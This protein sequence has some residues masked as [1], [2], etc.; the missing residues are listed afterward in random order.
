MRTGLLLIIIL[1]GFG[2]WSFGGVIVITGPGY[3][4][5]CLGYSFQI[6]AG[7]PETVTQVKWTFGDGATVTINPYEPT[8]HAYA[9]SGTYTVTALVTSS[10]GTYTLS[11]T[12]SMIGNTNASGAG[13]TA[14]GTGSPYTFTYTGVS[15]DGVAQFGHS[16]TLDFGDGTSQSGVAL[17]TGIAIASHSYTPGT[18]VVTLT[19]QFFVHPIVH[20]SWTYS[21][22]IV[23]AEDPCCTSFSPDPGNTYVLSAWVQEVASGPIMDYSTKVYIELEFVISGSNQLLR[24][25]PSGDIIEGWQRIVGS[26]TVPSGTTELKVNM[27]NDNTGIDAYYDDIRIHPFN[28]SMKSY[29][30]DPETLWLAAELDD[31]NYA[32]FYE[33]DKEGQLVRKKKETERG[34]FTIEEARSSNKK[35]D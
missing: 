32:T 26:F 16:Y 6:R 8:S 24:M 15:F 21:V 29:V 12:Q 11:V 35:K 5:D 19:H 28:G 27:V 18:Y 1:L 23:V 4:S 34:I 7:S 13:F 14:S 9:A 10:T 2:A 30:Y 31:N 22:T 25:Y 3:N 17:S 33:Y 20:C